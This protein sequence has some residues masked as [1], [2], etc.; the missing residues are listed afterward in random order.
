MIKVSI[1]IPFLKVDTYFVECLSSLRLITDK[2]VEL[3]LVHD[4]VLSPV[5]NE[6]LNKCLEKI[7]IPSTTIF[8]QKVGIPACLNLGISLSVGE[9]ICRFDSDDIFQ[10]SRIGIQRSYLDANLDVAAVGGQMMFIDENGNQ[11]RNRVSNYPVGKTETR[12]AFESGCYMAHPAVMYRK[13]SVQSVGSYRESFKYAED[14]DLWLRLLDYFE[15]DNVPEVVI[16]YREHSN[17]LSSRNE[18]V[19]CYSI[20]ATLARKNRILGKLPDIPETNFEE[21]VESLMDKQISLKKDIQIN[22]TNA[23]FRQELVL[24]KKLLKS[25]KFGALKVFVRLILLSLRGGKIKFLRR[26]NLYNG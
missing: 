12:K 10:I 6:L 14:Y 20:A 17:Q 26:S 16:Y 21:W 13:A 7:V 24:F 8:S 15:L 11:K 1:L 4:R 9:Y 5:E 19:S 2:D 25:K 3:I 23:Q 18:L 22:L